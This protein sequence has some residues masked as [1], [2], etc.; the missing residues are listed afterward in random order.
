ML[1][2]RAL[3]QDAFETHRL[4][5]SDFNRT[6]AG[7]L[8][9][10]PAVVCEGEDLYRRRCGYDRA[11]TGAAS[12]KA[13][14]LGIV[15]KEDEKLVIE[16]FR[17]GGFVAGWKSI[18]SGEFDTETSLLEQLIL[19]ADALK[20]SGFRVG[21]LVRIRNGETQWSVHFEDASAPDVA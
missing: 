10:V 12:A 9:S 18:D 6:Q 14:T 3:D 20:R 8:L 2:L 1:V 21:D 15:S 7:E 13:T 16:E 19:L 5:A 17:S 4:S 11:F